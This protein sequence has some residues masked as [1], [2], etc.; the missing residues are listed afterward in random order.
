MNPYAQQAYKN[1]NTAG[2][3]PGEQI[4]RLLETAAK[5]ILRAKEHA[6][7]EEFLERLNA[8]EDAL[9]IIHG[10]QSCLQRDEQTEQISNTL[11]SYYTHLTMQIMQINMKNDTDMCDTVSISLKE[12]AGTWR[13]IDRQTSGTTPTEE[14]PSSID[15][16][17]C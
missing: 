9:K 17:S 15:I 11:E 5:H 7:K 14:T 13:E 10:L 8:T 1:N 2:L 16:S 12:M 3:T 6:F 4:A